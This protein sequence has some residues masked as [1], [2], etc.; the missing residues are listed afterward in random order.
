[1][2][3]ACIDIGS[4]T[5]RLLVADCDGRTLRPVHEQ[6]HFTRIIEER[7]A[8][9]AIS[10]AKL[11]EVA[12]V[13]ALEALVARRQG[14]TVVHVVATA[15]V[16]QAGN[17][18]S[19]A[20]AVQRRC[21]LPLRILRE[22]EEAKLAFRG[23]VATLGRRTAEPLAVLDVGGGSTDIA[24]GHGPDRVD[25]TA[26]LPLGSGLLVSGWRG[27]DPPAVAQLARAQAL[28]HSRVDALQLPPCAEAIAV[29]GS[30]TSLR[31]LAGERLDERVLDGLLE[32]LTSAPAA[33]LAQTLGLE[34]ARVRLL[35][36]GLLILRALAAR[37]GVP[38]AI[39]RGGLREGVLLSA[40]AP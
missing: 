4:N 14:A 39:G 40:C 27:A 35:P 11:N 25:F 32:R 8:D 37:L 33:A 38:L 34:A 6:R 22:G 21:G 30:A 7:G 2:R 9:G 31:Q 5:T 15:A 12:G 3:C 10:A 28:V 23:A 26:S 16:R 13:V 36:G 20:D 1:L 24:V 17:A 29:G 19:L 18:A